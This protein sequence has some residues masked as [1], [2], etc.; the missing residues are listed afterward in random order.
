MAVVQP[1][2]SRNLDYCI[3]IEFL[4]TQSPKLDKELFF[5][6]FFLHAHKYS[7]MMSSTQQIAFCFNLLFFFPI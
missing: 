1:T 7:D 3:I 2:V 4:N 5:F 6:C